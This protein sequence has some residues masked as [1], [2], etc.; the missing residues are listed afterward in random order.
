MIWYNVSAAVSI[1]AVAS[2]ASHSEAF[3]VS[4]RRMIPVPPRPSFRIASAISSSSA[5]DCFHAKGGSACSSCGLRG[6]ML[7]SSRRT[8]RGSLSVRADRKDTLRCGLS[9]CDGDGDE[10]D[11]GYSWTGRRCRNSRGGFSHDAHRKSLRVRR[12]VKSRWVSAVGSEPGG[13][14]EESN[15]LLLRMEFTDVEVEDLRNWMRR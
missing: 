13:G 4:S 8:A 10:S 12:Q 11:S 1:A 2:L 6:T 7:N 5:V 9:T 3:A 15:A 14:G